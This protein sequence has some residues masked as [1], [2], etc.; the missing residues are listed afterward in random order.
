MGS[1]EF[2]D[3]LANKSDRS[4]VVGRSCGGD[5]GKWVAAFA[6]ALIFSFP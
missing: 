6:T 5:V 2:G 1:P 4:A 3:L